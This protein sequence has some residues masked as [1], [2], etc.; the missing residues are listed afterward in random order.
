MAARQ[1]RLGYSDRPSVTDQTGTK[2][3]FLRDSRLSVSDKHYPNVEF[4]TLR[5]LYK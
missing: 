4:F 5:S 3:L 1:K 2:R